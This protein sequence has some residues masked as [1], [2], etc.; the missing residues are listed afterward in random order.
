MQDGLRAVRPLDDDVGLR[1]AALEVAARALAPVE[2]L[3]ARGRLLRVDDHLELL[4]L[5]VDRP[6][7]RARLRERVGADGGDG[8]TLVAALVHELRDVARADRR[9]D[10]GQ[11]ERGREVDPGDVRVRVRR[12]E[13]RRVQHPREVEVGGVDGLAAGAFEPV[14]ALDRLPDDPARALGPL[15]ERVLLDD[16][17]DLLVPPLD[18]LL[19]PDQPRHVRIASSIFGYAPQRQMLPAMR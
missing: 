9:V 12:A 5:D 4:E 13:H 1:E 19:R 10:A 7:R 17:P 6:H 15:L 11:R 8:D 2:H 16:E 3:A 14:D 18:L